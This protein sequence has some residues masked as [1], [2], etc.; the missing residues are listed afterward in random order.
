MSVNRHVCAAQ[1][2]NIYDGANGGAVGREMPG[3]S[4]SLK[5][6]WSIEGGGGAGG[7]THREVG[8]P[9]VGGGVGWGFQRLGQG[10]GH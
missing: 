10:P 4:Q 6:F 9:S 3:V 2:V 7:E 8:E 1:G 5:R